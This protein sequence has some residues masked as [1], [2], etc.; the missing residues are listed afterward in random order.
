[1]YMIYNLL[2]GNFENFTTLKTKLKDRYK[3][4]ITKKIARLQKEITKII[5]KTQKEITK[6]LRGRKRSQKD[7]DIKVI[8]F[9]NDF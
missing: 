3:K 7:K 9:P 1:M 4:E 8:S 5:A 6:K 2:Q